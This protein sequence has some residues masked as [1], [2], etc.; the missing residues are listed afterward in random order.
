VWMKPIAGAYPADGSMKWGQFFSIDSLVY[1]VHLVSLNL[2]LWI[3]IE[4]LAGY[5]I[6]RESGSGYQDIRLYRVV[7]S[8]LI[9]II[10]V[11]EIE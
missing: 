1:L 4:Q 3:G 9:N 11:I 10:M 6:I 2:I 7:G 8:C 5:Q